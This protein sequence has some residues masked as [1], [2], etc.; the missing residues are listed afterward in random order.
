MKRKQKMKTINT[1]KIS[2]VFI[3]IVT[4]ILFIGCEEVTTASKN[5][6]EK[7]VQTFPEMTSLEQTLS[8]FA[9]LLP[10]ALM[11]P[12]LAKI[13]WDEVKANEDE[14]DDLYKKQKKKL[15]QQFGEFAD[16]A[17]FLDSGDGNCPDGYHWNR[18]EFTCDED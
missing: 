7:E 1:L 9:E 10:K 12:D 14:W 5:E 6:P 18:Q 16:E 2:V 4:M 17:T 11:D 13:V 15:K 8:D 3:G